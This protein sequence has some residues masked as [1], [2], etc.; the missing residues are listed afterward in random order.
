M[1]L[2]HFV[3]A[4]SSEL[5]CHDLVEHWAIYSSMTYVSPKIGRQYLVVTVP[6]EGWLRPPNEHGT[7]DAEQEPQPTTRRVIAYALPEAGDG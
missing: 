2:H 4:Y 6:G 7:S 5:S 3:D 1:H